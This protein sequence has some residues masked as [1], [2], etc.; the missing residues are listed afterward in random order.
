[1]AQTT[2]TLNLTSLK[3]H[4]ISWHTYFYFPFDTPPSIFQTIETIVNFNPVKTLY[5]EQKVA[6][7]LTQ[8]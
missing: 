6:Y 3:P 8:T 2:E 5:I 4:K 1:M 7:S